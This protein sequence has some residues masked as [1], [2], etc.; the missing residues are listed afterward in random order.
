[1]KKLLLSKSNALFLLSIFFILNL[2][3]TS[4]AEQKKSDLNPS[5]PSTNLTDLEKEYLKLEAQRNEDSSR[6]AAWFNTEREKQL[7]FNKP[8]IFISLGMNCAPA[9]RF[10]KKKLSEAFF[11][12]DWCISTFQSI[13]RALKTDFKNYLNLENLEVLEHTEKSEHR[14]VRDNLYDITYLHDFSLDKNPL[15]DYQEIQSKYYRRIDRF[16]RALTLGKEVYFFRTEITKKETIKLKALIQKKFPKLNYTLVVIN[17]TDEFKTPWNI[18]H[19]KNFFL[20]NCGYAG[21]KD[22]KLL[23][24]W[25][26]IFKE[27]KIIKKRKRLR[28]S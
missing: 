28:I 23:K 18:R 27:L 15:H 12:F 24:N 20:K 7:Y 26:T 21:R 9:L 6:L 16:Y 5:L 13:Y 14:V 11:P 19:V 25:D 8:R 3:F 22:K 1:M 2:T 4:H 17:E 10:E